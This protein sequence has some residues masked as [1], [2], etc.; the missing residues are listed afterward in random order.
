MCYPV[1]YFIGLR[2]CTKFMWRRGGAEFTSAT[3]LDKDYTMPPGANLNHSNI[4]LFM[5]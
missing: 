1:C 4:T 2:E 5:I 3:T